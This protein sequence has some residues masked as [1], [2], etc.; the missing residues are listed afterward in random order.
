MQSATLRSTAARTYEKRQVR[1]AR[2]WRKS[3]PDK[4][5]RRACHQTPGRIAM[6]GRLDGRVG[7]VSGALRGI[8]RAI[9]E[10]LA[11]DGATVII[12]DLDAEDSDAARAACAQIRGSSYI[13]LDATAEADWQ[14]ARD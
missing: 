13:M 6:T 4:D 1:G 11:A 12:T 14:A 3:S 5:G 2:A 8:G 10:C 9:A 7:L